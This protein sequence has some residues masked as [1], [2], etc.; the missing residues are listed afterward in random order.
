M[1]KALQDELSRLAALA[2][3]DIAAELKAAGVT[4]DCGDPYGC[5]LVRHLERVLGVGE[6]VLV[7]Y[8]GVTL[9]RAPVVPLPPSCLAFV[10]GVDTGRYPGVVLPPDEDVD[11]VYAPEPVSV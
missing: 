8:D 3:D 1:M 7:T 9:D 4:G 10:E 11:D 6:G 5:P 2:P